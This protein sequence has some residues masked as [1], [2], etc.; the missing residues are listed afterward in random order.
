MNSSY[1]VLRYDFIATSY[2]YVLP[3]GGTDLFLSHA[4]RFAEKISCINERKFA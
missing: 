4:R 2:K 3:E 1:M